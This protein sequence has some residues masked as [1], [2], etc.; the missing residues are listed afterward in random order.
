M[1]KKLFHSLCFVAIAVFLASVALI[2]GVLYG[3]FSRIQQTQLRMQTQLAAQ[4]VEKSGL[5]YFAGLPVKDYRITWIGADGKV[6]YDTA[7]DAAAMTDHQARTEVREALES[8]FGQDQRLSAT[9]TERMLYAAQRLN[10]GTVLR[11]AIAQSSILTMLLGVG[12]GV[13]AVILLALALSVFLARRLSQKIVAPLNEVD[14]D[15]P[16]ENPGYEELTPLLRRLDAQQRQLKIQSAQLELAAAE[17]AE[18]EAMR[19]QFTANVSHELKTPLHVISGY[20]ELMRNGMVK[21]EDVGPFAGR[22]YDEA[23]LMGKLVEDVI[24]LSHLDEGA[25]DMPFE[26]AD[27]ADIA[28]AAVES[29]RPEAEKAGV[30]LAFTG[31]AAP[32]EGIPT[33]LHSIVFN[34]CEN[35]IKYNRPG[36]HVAVSVEKMPAGTV[37]TVRDDGAGIPLEQQEHV[38]ERFYRGDRSRSRDVPGTGLGLSIVKHAAAV[39]GGRIE[40]KSAPGQGTE[41]TVTFPG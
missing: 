11:L 14:L 16:M 15:R 38:F 5:D 20:A 29:L 12:Q 7:V 9:L 2:M 34:L 28:A 41:I 10:D 13:A 19:R 26:P 24:S 36:G 25:G 40:L 3:Y 27:L 4:G 35:G 18:A 32:M 33:L 37:L 21:P 22:I 39:H 1:T 8:G 17:R 23:R 6:L 30:E 31:E